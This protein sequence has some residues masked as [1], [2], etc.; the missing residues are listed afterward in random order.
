MDRWST[1]RAWL[2]RLDPLLAD[3]L[4]ALVAAGLAQAELQEQPG[5]RDRGALN[6]AFVLLQ[7]LPLVARRRVDGCDDV[8]CDQAPPSPP[9]G[10]TAIE[11]RATA[12]FSPPSSAI[13][14]FQT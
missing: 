6:V 7:T 8:R 1:V 5:P 9:E 14:T 3:G 11:Q 4:V 13:S 2:P 10:L 12:T